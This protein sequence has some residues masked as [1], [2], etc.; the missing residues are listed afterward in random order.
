MKALNDDT[1]K[2]MSELDPNDPLYLRLKEELRLTNEHFYNLLKL[3]QQ[4]T[5]ADL[6]AA[7]DERLAGT[8]SCPCYL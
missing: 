6:S 8:F 4:P 7:F 5:S 1:H 3:S 2:L